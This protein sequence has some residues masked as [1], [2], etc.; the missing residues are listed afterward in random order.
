[1]KLTFEPNYRLLLAAAPLA[2]LLSAPLHAA[3]GR[4]MQK[5]DANGDAAIDLAE[6]QA[7][8]PKFTA[9]QFAAID[10]NHDGLL[11]R[12]ELRDS[13]PRGHRSKLDADSDGN[14]SLAELQKQQPGVTAEQYAALVTLAGKGARELFTLQRAALAS[15]KL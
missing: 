6:M 1:M 5:L 8:R 4:M 2:L 3:E 10:A 14:I 12:D 11:N 9:E 15:A 13:H 7:V